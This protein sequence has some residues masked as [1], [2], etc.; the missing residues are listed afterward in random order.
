MVQ[1]PILVVLDLDKTVWDFYAERVEP[2]A[3]S[4][5]PCA[6]DRNA[7]G[8]HD[9]VESRDRGGKRKWNLHSQSRAV[10]KH[11]LAS[12]QRFVV[13]V[14]SASP[15][16]STARKLLR[17]YGLGA[18]VRHSQ[19]YSG[20]K[21]RHLRVIEAETKISLDSNCIFFDDAPVFLSQARKLGVV[22]V[23]VD[24]DVGVT[25][26]LL[27]KGLR[28]LQSK[29]SSARILKSFCHTN[30]DNAPEVFSVSKTKKRTAPSI[31]DFM[32]GSKKKK[33]PPQQTFVDCPVCFKSVPRLNINHHVSKCLEGSAVS[34]SQK[35]KLKNAGGLGVKRLRSGR[36]FQGASL[37]PGV[38]IFKDFVSVEEEVSLIADLRRSLPAW[39]I[40]HWNGVHWNKEW[41]VKIRFEGPANKST[42]DPSS[43]GAKLPLFL[44]RIADKFTCGEYLPV[45]KF[46]PNECNAI[47]YEK[48]LGHFLGPVSNISFYQQ[49]TLFSSVLMNLILFCFSTLTIEVTAESCL[50]MFRCAAMRR[51]CM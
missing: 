18:L 16:T 6:A 51:C 35:S 34:S 1:P 39:K 24:P 42:I 12:P 4:L 28:E 20:S 22:A 50:Q 8:T 46:Y 17:L 44:K 14:A 7:D 38:H 27:E 36:S 11:L 23:K 48:R 45:S 29:R 32:Q 25:L 37:L 26:T 21:D 47:K 3:Q 9:A 33:K 10:A 49:I 30:S 43:L 13:R 31:L 40:S 5:R 15:A 41:G 19:I 2:W